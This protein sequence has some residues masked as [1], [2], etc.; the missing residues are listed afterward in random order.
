[1]QM[2]DIREK[3]KEYGLK[4]SGMKKQDLIKQIQVAEGNF[5]CFATAY[6]GICD[7]AGCLWRDDCMKLSAASE[8]SH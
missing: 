6:D 8:S 2:Q 1:M 7:Q 4:T 3:A 5:D